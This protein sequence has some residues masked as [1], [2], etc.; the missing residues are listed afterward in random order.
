ML[1]SFVP[2]LSNHLPPMLLLE[3]LLNILERERERVR[4]SEREKNE[5]KTMSWGEGERDE[6][7]EERDRERNCGCINTLGFSLT[8]GS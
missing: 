8:N 5:K 4:E 2:T 1:S 6:E 3:S 7:E